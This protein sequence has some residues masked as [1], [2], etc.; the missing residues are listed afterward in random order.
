MLKSR[1]SASFKRKTAL[2]L[3]L[4]PWAV[5]AQITELSGT[6]ALAYAVSADG[7]TVVGEQGGNAYFWQNGTLTALPAGGF[8]NLAGYRVSGDGSVVVG[9]GVTGGNLRALVWQ[10][11]GAPTNLGVI[12]GD[13]GSGAF[14][15][16]SDGS[17]VVGWSGV[18]GGITRAFRWTS[19][20]GMVALPLIAGGNS[21]GAADV[22]GV[23][24]VV[25]GTGTIAG[26]LNRAF[27]W[28]LG[29]ANL[30]DLGTLA[31][32]TESFGHAISTDGN[33]V[34]GE[35]WAPGNI[36][37][38]FRWQGGT[39]TGL[40]TL[41]GTTSQAYDVSADGAVVVG[42]SR[43]AAAVDRGFRWTQAGGMQTVED[44]LRSTGVTVAADSTLDAR[45]VNQD[46]S[47]VAGRLA[48]GLAYIARAGSGL[49]TVQDLQDGLGIGAAANGM[50]LRST[51]L[52]IH[53]VHSDP[54]LR[55]VPAG[56][57]VFWTSGDWGLDDH[58]ARNGDLGLAEIGAGH[59]W[60]TW[61]LNAAL[62]Q[63]RAKQ[64]LAL[65][66]QAK[67]SGVFLL[68]EAMR[69]LGRDVWNTYSIYRHH[70]D[71]ELRR[72][73]WNAGLLDQSQA[74]TPAITTG[75]R[76]RLDWLQAYQAG[77]V[78]FSPYTDLLYAVSKLDGYTETGGGF[79][80]RF[81][82]RREY[83]TELHLGTNM[84]RPLSSGNKL[85]GS[86][87]AVHRFDKDGTRSSGEV[88]GLTAFNFQDPKNKRDWLQARLGVEG[89]AADGKGSLGINITTQG[90]TASVWLAASWVKAFD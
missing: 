5:Q 68:G 75:V 13:P 29:D 27:R 31:G 73:Y 9:Y 46:G 23:G 41:G 79:P 6:A 67:T 52:L 7:S 63:T 69:P 11:G 19:G 43:T 76:A 17:V 77:R 16:S 83:S 30:T 1:S 70:G 2:L 85:V 18:N 47:V 58:G 44:W 45:G 53:G 64:A 4:I 82:A 42:Q 34:V 20:G 80:A 37:Q 86:L 49:I 22:S 90:E 36:A 54:M 8:T 72:G 14:G 60:G 59:N 61:Q 3:G 35:S 33:V 66:S 89:P 81:D 87:A 24:T 40:G 39:M 10:N 55:R 71:F 65:N 88:I 50:A 21:A 38:A 25:A 15:V 32:N 56:R 74:R 51:R 28:T 62:G 57:N 12:G 84:S 26:G 78:S 48:S